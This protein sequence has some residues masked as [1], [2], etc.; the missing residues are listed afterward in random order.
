MLM[1]GHQHAPARW[2]TKPVDR[3]T[4]VKAAAAFSAL[5]ASPTLLN[6][7]PTS[8]QNAFEDGPFIRSGFYS[9]AIA[10]TGFS[11]ASEEAVAFVAEFPFSA[12]GAHW[13][14]EAPENC[15]VVIEL[16]YDGTNWSPASELH[17]SHDGHEDD[18]DGRHF[19][20]LM[21]SDGHQHVRYRSYSPS[22]GYYEL[23]DLVF[24]Y[25]DAFDGPS[26]QDMGLELAVSKPS[27]ISRSA[28]GANESL[29]FENQDPDE[30]VIN[31]PRY[32][33][34]THAVIH[35]SV[36]TNNAEPYATMR[37][38][39]YYHAITRGWGDIGY[40][41]L[42]DHRGNIFEGRFG[43]EN[44]IGTHSG[45]F[46]TG[47]CGIC[48]LGTFETTDI[49]ASAQASL[50]SMVAWVLRNQNPQAS[51]YLQ[52]NLLPTIFGHRN[53]SQTSCPGDEL[54][55]DLPYIREVA[56]D[57]LGSGSGPSEP[58]DLRKGQDV[59]IT[60]NNANVRSGPGTNFSVIRTLNA[61]TT[62]TIDGGPV[63]AHGYSWYV[64][65]TSAGTGW[66][67]T[68]NFAV[69]A[70]PAG[71]FKV[72]DT[73]RTTGTLSLRS[74]AGT[75]FGIIAS[76]AAGTSL[77]ITYAYNRANGYEWYKVTGP[78]GSGWA[79]GEFLQKEKPPGAFATGARV[80][81]NTDTLTLRASAGTNKAVLATM[82]RGTALRIT[83]AYNAANGYEWY[84]VTGAYGD[85][86][87]AGAFLRTATSSSGPGEPGGTLE[88][89]VD[90][91][92]YTNDT[93]VNMRSQPSTSGTVLHRVAKGAK[94]QV[95]EGPR[96]ANGYTW[97]RVR[98][99]QYGSGWI[100]ANY[101]ERR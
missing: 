22:G 74:G 8:A 31:A 40:N 3:R 67:A 75:G 25:I 93:Q 27:I 84:K 56:A 20:H 97:W 16:S 23:P 42:V 38:I 46:N 64:V 76:M 66:M 28:W 5:A 63:A 78:Y 98:N 60:T 11:L 32:E 91:T 55:A 54:Y 9:E 47:S 80:V 87:V 4:V 68:I 26:A 44:V 15:F 19:S 71:A 82:P 61:G 58:G 6:P 48:A 81:V 95:I 73:V 12:I 49:S 90:Y 7:P 77:R 10:D 18:R 1:S 89:K 86:W 2:F 99:S 41:Y 34:V 43:G 53:I 57:L 101:L 62:G 72:N 30:P 13:A 88:I 39:Y 50:I 17:E 85:G 35:H 92:V 100:V 52:G 83:Y 29:R 69:A 24:T 14:A 36:T 51:A 96:S 45:A 21:P 70:K 94:F 37:S 79:A 65:K 33:P 59:S